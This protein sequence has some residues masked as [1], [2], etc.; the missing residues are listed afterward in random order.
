MLW[1]APN[2]RPFFV[3]TTLME[4]DQRWKISISFCECVFN[5]LFLDDEE[6][7]PLKKLKS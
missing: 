5:F 1:R 4:I 6:E 3:V 7:K 2:G